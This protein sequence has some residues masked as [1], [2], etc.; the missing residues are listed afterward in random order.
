[1]P[2]RDQAI[3]VAANAEAGAL[4]VAV[5]DRFN[6]GVEGGA[7]DLGKLHPFRRQGLQELEDGDDVPQRSVD[8]IELRLFAVVGKT[9]R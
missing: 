4:R 3:L 5:E 9:V 8:G 1:L 6:G 2:S 7:V